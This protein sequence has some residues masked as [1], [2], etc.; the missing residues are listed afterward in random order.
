[1][2]EMSICLALIEQV[3]RIAAER[4]ARS[5]SVI[6]VSIGPLSGIEADLLARAFPLAAAG[7]PA[8]SATLDI[9]H[10]DVAVRCSQCGAESPA[11]ANRLLCGECGD[12]RTTIV[13]GDEMILQR[14]ELDVPAARSLAI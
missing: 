12:F 11:R 6:T 9:E 4:G 7:T 2:H 5:V 1:M 13:S 10:I 8:E 3:E 14:V